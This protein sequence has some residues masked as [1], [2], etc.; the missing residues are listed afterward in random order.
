MSKIIKNTP[1]KEVLLEIKL[2]S[3]KTTPID[4]VLVLN[5]LIT[6]VKKDYPE[7][8]SLPGASFPID[9]PEPL[10]RHRIL[11]KDQKRL[12]NVGVNILSINTLDYKGYENFKGQVKEIV[13]IYLDLFKDY[14]ISRIGLRYINIL[15]LKKEK[16]KDVLAY[17]NPN[18]L[19]KKITSS[20]FVNLYKYSENNQLLLKQSINAPKPN[21]VSVDIDYSKILNS[22]ESLA[23]ILEWLDEGHDRIEEAFNKSFVEGYLK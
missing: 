1:L 21:N 17:D 5:K 16:V 7:V 10:S 13:E 15:D 4:Y 18:P 2:D 23:R 22:R 19:G 20:E 6:K 8:L 3:K 14:S 9:F 12:M 11:S